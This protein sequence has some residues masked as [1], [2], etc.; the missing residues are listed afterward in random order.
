MATGP[1]HV[2]AAVEETP[3]KKAASTTELPAPSGWTKK[4]CLYFP[5]GRPL[6]ISPH[7]LRPLL[8]S[9]PGVAVPRTPGAC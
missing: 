6:P 4:V 5:L 1:E 2:A 7:A 9:G 3:E 8:A